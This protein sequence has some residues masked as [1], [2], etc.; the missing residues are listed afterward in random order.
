MHKH[1]L[2]G[3]AL[4]LVVGGGVVGVGTAASSTNPDQP[5]P[6]PA[7]TIE[8]APSVHRQMNSLDHRTRFDMILYKGRLGPGETAM[9]KKELDAVVSMGS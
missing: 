4:V 3:L 2:S 9:T 1:L 7:P 5:V 6:P 8:P